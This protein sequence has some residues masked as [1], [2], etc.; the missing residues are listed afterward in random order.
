MTQG[1]LNASQ[2]GG[3]GMWV[4]LEYL[5]AQGMFRLFSRG[6]VRINQIEAMH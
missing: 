4:R 3:T 6:D 2:L 5:E 1:S